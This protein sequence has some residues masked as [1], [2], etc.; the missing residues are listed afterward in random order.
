MMDRKH[1]F[2]GAPQDEFRNTYD[3]GRASMGCQG[4]NEYSAAAVGGR[5]FSNIF[6]GKMEC[7]RWT[8]WRDTN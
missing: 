2:D 1:Q 8:I 3:V 6:D 5:S 7:L 4:E